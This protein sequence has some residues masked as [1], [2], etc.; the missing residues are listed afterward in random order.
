M[1]VVIVSGAVNDQQ[2]LKEIDSSAE[3][4]TV[5]I[6]VLIVYYDSET[7]RIRALLS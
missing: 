2:E 4:I 6:Q 5:V 3:I 1:R 7:A